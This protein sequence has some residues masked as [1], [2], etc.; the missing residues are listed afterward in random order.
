MAKVQ[1]LIDNNDWL[2]VNKKHFISRVHPSVSKLHPFKQKC[3]P[4]SKNTF[5]IRFRQKIE[6]VCQKTF[7]NIQLQKLKFMCRLG[8]DLNDNVI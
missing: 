1:L 6:I 7:K 4:S 3:A 2:I 5:W 8:H